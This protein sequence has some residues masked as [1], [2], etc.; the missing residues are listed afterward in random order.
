MKVRHPGES[1]PFRRMVASTLL[2]LPLV[3]APAAATVYV[4][5]NLVTDNQANLTASGYTPADHVDPNLV[6]PWGIALSATSPFWVSDNGTHVS[7]LY[8]NGAPQLNPLV[9]AIPPLNPT[10][11]PGTTGTPTGIVFNDTAGTGNFNRDLFLFATEDGL[12]AGWQAANASSAATRFDNSGSSANYK[13]LALGTN[14]SGSFLYAADFRNARIDVINS[15]F[16]ATALAGSFTDPNLPAGYAP[17]NIQNL[18]GTLYVT[19]AQQ[20]AG[21]DEVAG[22]GL[23]YV[24]AYDTNGVLL[25]RVAS[26]GALNA[27]WGLALAPADFGEFSNDLLVGNFGDG[28]IHAF[29][30]L[31]GVFEGTLSDANGNPIKID[32]L[33]GLIFGNGGAGG[34]ADT[35]YFT[36]GINDEAHGLFGSL[37]VPEPGTLALAV[38]GLAALRVPRRRTAAA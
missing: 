19:Y 11:P 38:A 4:Q 27:P 12:I 9:V 22:P 13:G 15:T 34:R 32:G 7:T 10:P 25:R 37:S 20:G 2:A 5:H 28:L 6:N 33:W 23:G 30:P 35:L 26:G 16:A 8:P 31:T 24:D 14:N 17:F 3:S 21:G 18:G 29:D 1:R 36:A